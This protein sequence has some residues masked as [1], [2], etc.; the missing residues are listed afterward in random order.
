[1]LHLEAAGRITEQVRNYAF[2]DGTLTYSVPASASG[3]GTV[4]YSIW[5]RVP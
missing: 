4:A 1:M 2:K 3:N 5:R